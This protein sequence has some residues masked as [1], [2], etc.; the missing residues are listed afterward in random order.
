M[1]S[2]MQKSKLLEYIF[3][4]ADGLMKMYIISPEK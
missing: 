1:K 2:N 4:T 3:Q